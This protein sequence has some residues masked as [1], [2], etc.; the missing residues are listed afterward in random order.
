MDFEIIILYEPEQVEVALSC[1]NKRELATRDKLRI[2]ALDYEVEIALRQRG[3]PY[4]SLQEYFTSDS[5]GLGRYALQ[6]SQKWFKAPEMDFFQHHNIG[7]LEVRGPDFV[8]YLK[9]ILYYLEALSCVLDRHP[10]ISKLWIPESSQFVPLT[11]GPVAP[12]A[13]KVPVDVAMLLGKARGI[14]V[15][16]LP[17][18]KQQFYKQRALSLRRRLITF[19]FERVLRI[20]NF[21]TNITRP[22]QELKLF[23]IDHW[24]NIGSFIR[25][26]N[27]VELVMMERK[28][29]LKMG[30]QFW[31]KRA[32]FY[33]RKDFITPNIRKIAYDKQARFRSIWDGLSASPK[34]PEIFRH[35]D[36]SFWPV[37]KQAVNHI[38]TKD[39][40]QMICEIESIKRLLK[41]FSINRILLRASFH[42]HFY[43]IAKLARQMGIPSL[44]LQHGLE[45]SE[46]VFGYSPDRVEC[47]A[48]YGKLT[49]EIFINQRND[50]QRIAKVGSPRFDRYIRQKSDRQ[51]VETLRT[52]LNLDPSHPVI[53]LIVPLVMAPVMSWTYNSYNIVEIFQSVRKAQKEMPELQ[54]V[55]RP[56]SVGLREQFCQKVAAEIF[57]KDAIIAEYEDIKTLLTLSDVV[58]SSRSTVV[59]EA[60]IIGKPVILFTMK[61]GVAQ[62]QLFED[63]G[64]LRIAHTA[65]EIST[66]I[67]SL[68]FNSKAREEMIKNASAFL[69]EN[70]LFD[71]KSSARIVEILKKGR[72]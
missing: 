72:C 15:S 34:F 70:Y 26:M 43:V 39:A 38:I 1:F 6:I 27:N 63:A 36:I 41:H 16:A 31:K 22:P 18:N 37:V 68:I 4:I 49:K 13:Y 51:T 46:S 45:N 12:F 62:F 52:R 21:L 55:L 65:E 60:M 10:N 32:R 57:K 47:F 11:A 56:R 71:G 33:H 24:R 9:L 64:A 30:R 35:K 54:V 5:G 66:H 3:I 59:L 40:E 2:V 29:I 28:E 14:S 50:P 23:V 7:L 42:D 25:K 67:H 53:L 58:V 48:A 19:F 17:C 20:V 69:K 61:G 44:E 8:Y